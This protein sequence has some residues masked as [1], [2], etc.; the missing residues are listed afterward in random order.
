MIAPAEVERLPAAALDLVVANS[1][2]QYLTRAELERL[3]AIWRRI[4][5]PGGRLVVADVIGPAQSALADALALLRFAAA[6][7]FLFAALFGL[8]RTVFSD[9]RK[10][11]ARLGLAHYAE[12]DMLAL[13]SRAGFAA[14]RLRP[15]LGHNQARMAFRAVKPV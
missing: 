2:M 12:A 7:G 15:N 3:L 4:L 11:R 1:L 8:A 5:K 10:L 6:N 13:L 9:Y 14:E